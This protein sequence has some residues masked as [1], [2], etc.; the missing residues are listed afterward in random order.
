MRVRTSALVA[1][2]AGCTFGWSGATVVG[3]SRSGATNEDTAECTLYLAPSHASPDHVGIYTGQSLE[4]D[5]PLSRAPNAALH[6]LHLAEKEEESEQSGTSRSLLRDMSHS[7]RQ[8]A[9]EGTDASH[10]TQTRWLLLA[11]VR[12]LAKSHASGHGNVHM[13]ESSELLPRKGGTVKM[14]TTRFVPAGMELL[15]GQGGKHDL[16]RDQVKEE[17][18][19]YEQADKIVD[20]LYQFLDKHRDLSPE[21]QEQVLEFIT[22]HVLAAPVDYDDMDDTED[23]DTDDEEDQENISQL[24]PKSV[25]KL[26]YVHGNS[27]KGNTG[28]TFAYRNPHLVVPMAWLKKYGQ[29]YDGIP[30]TLEWAT[31]KIT[32]AGMGVIA[33]RYIA[34]DSWILPMPLL[35]LPDGISI[36]HGHASKQEEMVAEPLFN[37]CFG[38]EEST[39]LLCPIGSGY[40]QYINHGSKDE[41]NVKI[42]WS[43]QEWHQ[44]NHLLQSKNL[45]ELAKVQNVGSLVFD[46]VSTKPIKVGDEL[47]LNYGD[48]WAQAWEQYH[49]AHL[50]R[51]DDPTTPGTQQDQPDIFSHYME[52]PDELFPQA[53]RNLHT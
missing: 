8:G 48:S 36:L 29:C 3:A 10:E 34:Q 51:G 53:W 17:G 2:A 14:R 18:D 26:N 44:T 35:H 41:A 20:Q 12:T 52:V 1:A 6:L 16:R 7:V 50:E 28:G 40:S 42:V 19:D 9:G 30:N 15:L 47:L 39:V 25:G 37:Y 31:S 46:L 32:G 5:S 21:R 24:M 23:H 13:D 4:S 45:T 38:H 49:F 43:K 22:K 11:G 33:K 27:E